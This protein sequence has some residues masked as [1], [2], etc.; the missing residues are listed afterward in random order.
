M[1][2]SPFTQEEEKIMNLLIEAHN[3]IQELPD[4]KKFINEWVDGIHKCQN[5]LIVRMVGRL[6]PKVFN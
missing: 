5:V 2:D 4:H 6:Y 3:L 1:K